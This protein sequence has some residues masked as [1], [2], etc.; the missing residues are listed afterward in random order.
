MKAFARADDFEEANDNEILTFWQAQVK[1]CQERISTARTELHRRQLSQSNSDAISDTEQREAAYE[2]SVRRR[3][4]SRRTSNTAVAW[5][6]SWR[7]SIS[8]RQS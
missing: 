1:R 4:R 3:S 5:H 2:R 7:N 6:D 8:V